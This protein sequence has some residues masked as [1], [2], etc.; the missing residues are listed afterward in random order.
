M[1]HAPGVNVDSQRSHAKNE[2]ATRSESK[3]CIGRTTHI[4]VHHRA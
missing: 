1:L 2:Q 3:C 4:R